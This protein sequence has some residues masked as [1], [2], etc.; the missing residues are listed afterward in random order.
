[1]AGLDVWILGWS[2]GAA[3]VVV[4]AALLL[5][6]LLVARGIEREAQRVLAAARRIDAN[7]RPIWRLADVREC[8]VTVRDELDHARPQQQRSADSSPPKQPAGEVRR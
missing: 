8:L 1:M 6:I 3:V 7:T 4:A 2:I 5:W